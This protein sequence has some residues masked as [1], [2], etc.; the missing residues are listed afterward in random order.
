MLFFGNTN[1]IHKPILQKLKHF[2]MITLRNENIFIFFANYV[3]FTHIHNTNTFLSLRLILTISNW[4]EVNTLSILFHILHVFV[5]YRDCEGIWNKYCIYKIFKVYH[6]KDEY[7]ENIN[8][9]K[10][11]CVVGKWCCLWRCEWWREI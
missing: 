8:F 4:K 7:K 6:V 1:L 11:A 10:F 5:F 9:N 3:L 2:V